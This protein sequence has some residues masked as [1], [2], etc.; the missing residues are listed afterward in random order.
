TRRPK[1]RHLSGPPTRTRG[2]PDV[3]AGA[4][5]EPA[6]E[7]AAP[8]AAEAEFVPLEEADKETEGAKSATAEGGDDEP[9][10]EALDDT[11][12]IVPEE[13]EDEDVTD[14]I[15]DGIEDDEET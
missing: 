2:R 9:E 15:G 14:I 13:D 12:F 8:E 11:T 7:V 3:A 1:S 4:A 5:P 6:D 10:D